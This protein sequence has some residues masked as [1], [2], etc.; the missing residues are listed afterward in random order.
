LTTT[1]CSHP[2]CNTQHTTTPQ[3][4]HRHHT[5]N[6]ALGRPGRERYREQH[7]TRCLL[8]TQQCASPPPASTTDVA[9][10]SNAWNFSSRSVP[11]SHTHSPSRT[12]VHCMIRRG[13]SERRDTHPS[14]VHI[15][16]SPNGETP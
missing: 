12:G 15:P 8:R 16:T 10:P 6:R 1:R 9:S 4:S 11:P 2:L 13:I 7:P 5:N 14:G 3:P